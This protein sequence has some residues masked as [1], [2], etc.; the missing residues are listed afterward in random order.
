V[1]KAIFIFTSKFNNS[2]R[3]VIDWVNFFEKPYLINNAKLI[4]EIYHNLVDVNNNLF[5]MME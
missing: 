1:N 2:I 4:T 3:E 5:S